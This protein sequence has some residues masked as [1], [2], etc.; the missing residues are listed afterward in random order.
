[1]SQIKDF[2]SVVSANVEKVIIG[3]HNVIEMLMVALLCEG[4]VL[5]FFIG[6]SKLGGANPQPRNFSISCWLQAKYFG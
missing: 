5:A 6:S 1:M 4:H 2:V 3:K